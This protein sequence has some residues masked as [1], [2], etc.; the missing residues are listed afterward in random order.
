MADKVDFSKGI[1]IIISPTENGYACGIINEP[2]EPTDFKNDGLYLCHV[3]AQ[4]MIKFSMENPQETFD[5]GV[6]QIKTTQPRDNGGITRF[7]EHNNVVDLMS[8][9]LTKKKDLN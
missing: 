2:N 6:D 8:L 7:P 4:G 5:M 9:L 1:K 3:I